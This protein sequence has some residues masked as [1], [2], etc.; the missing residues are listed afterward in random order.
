MIKSVT[1]TNYL[2]ESKTFVLKNP[3]STGFALTDMEGVGPPKASINT[4]EA[5][6]VD[7]SF[8]NSSRVQERNIVLTFHFL[9]TDDRTVED[10]RLEAYKYFPVK[11]YV[12]LLV[13]TEHRKALVSGYVES[14][15]P[16]IFSSDVTTQV[17][18]IC[19]DPYFY[20]EAITNTTFFGV[21]PLFE[22]PF[23]NP[24]LTVPMIE[25]GKI[26]NVTQKTVVYEGDAETGV[27]ITLHAIG[28]VENITIY[29]VDTREVMKLDTEKLEAMTGSPFSTSDEI[30]IS[31]LKGNKYIQLL[32]GGVYT[33]ILN[34]LDKDSN[35][36][37]LAK[38][39]NRF[40][41]L[42]EDGLEN[43]QFRMENRTVYEGV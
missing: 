31:T 35:W 29:N 22:F 19:P 13:E 38:G 3:W 8:F 4:T 17:S 23:E 12:T 16:N 33:N 5:A 34:I 10:V 28:P 30:I 11:R 39:D 37:Q 41:Y 40:A 2:G 26:N 27:V 24:S 42:A 15:E 18:I 20:S 1:V 21:D 36:F 43:L 6:T 32:R 7:G 25:M 9:Q 14:N